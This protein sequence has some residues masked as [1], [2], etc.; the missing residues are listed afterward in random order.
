VTAT[1]RLICSHDTHTK[2][3]A[4]AVINGRR[5]VKFAVGR[6][7]GYWVRNTSDIRLL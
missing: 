2:V 6:L 5:Y 3:K 7:A 4:V 1:R